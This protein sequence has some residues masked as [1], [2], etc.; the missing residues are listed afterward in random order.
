LVQ[1]LG[2]L[3]FDMIGELA[4]HG[5]TEVDHSTEAG[6]DLMRTAFE[7]SRLVP[8]DDDPPLVTAGRS[9]SKWFYGPRDFADLKARSEAFEQQRLK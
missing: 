5:L 6:E 2:T 1:R 7:V 8:H 4:A 9:L 3:T